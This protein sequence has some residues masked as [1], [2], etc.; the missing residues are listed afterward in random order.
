MVVVFW[1]Q[2]FSKALPVIRRTLGMEDA[3]CTTG[4]CGDDMESNANVNTG[5]DRL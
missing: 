3:C 5:G 4:S 2:Q 1:Q